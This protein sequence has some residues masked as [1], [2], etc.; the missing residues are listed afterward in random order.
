MDVAEKLYQQMKEDE[1]SKRSWVR[2]FLK[3]GG[4]ECPDEEVAEMAW[5]SIEIVKEERA[6]LEE[7]ECG[8]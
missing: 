7:T 4:T 1:A 8:G 3:A 6:R 2:A 5:C